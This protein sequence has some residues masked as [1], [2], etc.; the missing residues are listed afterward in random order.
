[1]TGSVI[2]STRP[3]S[4]LCVILVSTDYER[5]RERETD[6]QTDRQTERDTD[7]GLQTHRHRDRDREKRVAFIRGLKSTNGTRTTSEEQRDFDLLLLLCL[8]CIDNADDSVKASGRNPVLFNLHNEVAIDPM[9]AA[10]A[11]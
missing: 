5:E 9:H 6:R 11:D 3:S 2:H 10:A 7:I 1:M 4:A 8:V